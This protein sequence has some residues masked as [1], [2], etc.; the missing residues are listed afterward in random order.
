MNKKK[1]FMTRFG[2]RIKDMLL[3]RLLEMDGTKTD[4][5]EV[6]NAE[7]IALWTKIYEGRA[8]W[9]RDAQFDT[10]GNIAEDPVLDSG[11][12]AAL[13]A[14]M[15]RLITLR[16]ET[17][18]RGGTRAAFLNKEYQ[19]VI[20][21]LRLNMEY[22]LAKG[23]MVMK[24]FVHKNRIGVQF[25]QPDTFI[26]LE[27]N[28]LGEMVDIAF[29]D[30]VEVGNK[31]ITKIERHVFDEDS[32]TYTIYNNAYSSKRYKL[33]GELGSEVSLGSVDSWSDLQEVVSFE[34][35]PRPLFV[36][37]KP[38]VANTKDSSSEL[39][40][41]I[42]AKV[43]GLL[44][45]VDKLYSTVIWEYEG[46]QLAIDT[47]ASL[48][49]NLGSRAENGEPLGKRG[50]S[51]RS[52]R[53]YRSLDMKEES[54]KVFSPAIRDANYFNGWNKLLRRIEFNIGLAYGTISEVND[55][56]KTAEEIR[57][58][59]GR[60]FNTIADIQKTLE[61]SLRELV[62]VMDIMSDIYGFEGENN[63]D[64]EITFKWDA[65]TVVDEKTELAVLLDEVKS[66]ILKP[67]YYLVKRYGLTMEEA[68]ERIPEVM[69]SSNVEGEVDNMKGD[70]Y[71][72][73]NKVKSLGN[74]SNEVNIESQLGNGSK[75][76]ENKTIK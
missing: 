7:Q 19:K 55:V 17:D 36:Y 64:Y 67:E 70:R 14:E 9:V 62:K 25:R 15:A 20:K 44:K 29:V 32:E 69:L 34:N 52:R 6:K 13:A 37:F 3:G 58:S 59:K 8:P 31:V 28:S 50:I 40:T 45:E 26:P 49:Y 21:K 75:L 71:T 46:T 57:S 68:I 66:G 48:F 33:T 12:A 53:L 1:N 73:D 5:V 10:D 47:D 56:E 74:K 27:F 22:A 43:E 39:G 76:N 63:E 72:V 38:P 24:P 61:D 4:S 2:D 60:T 42:F 41:S 16:T 23:S 11:T 30:R 18:V 51:S 35:I 65:S 54:F